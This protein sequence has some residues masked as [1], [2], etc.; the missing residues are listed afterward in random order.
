MTELCK[1]EV[2]W[3]EERF[4]DWGKVRWGRKKEGG[5]WGDNLRKSVVIALHDDYSLKWDSFP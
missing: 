5:E 3:K 2:G 1:F 4:V